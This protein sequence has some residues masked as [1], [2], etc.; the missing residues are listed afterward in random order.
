MYL[1]KL[2]WRKFLKSYK[3]SK[4]QI[5]VSHF[6]EAIQFEGFY[7]SYSQFGE[8]LIL[9]NILQHKEKGF[10]VDIGCNRPIEGNN[11][12]KFYLHGW[13]GINIDG[14]EK[15][16]KQFKK[17]RK[18][19]ISLC[20]IV[21]IN[22]EKIKFFISDDDRVS[23]I[24]EEFK[25]WI[26]E[27]RSYQNYIYVIPKTLE[28]IL[29]QYLPENTKIDFMNIDVEG[30]DL[31]VLNSN[32]FEKHRPGIICIEDHTFSF[33]KKNESKIHQ[34]LIDKNY[35]VI[36]YSSPNLYFKDNSYLM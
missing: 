20:E 34:C 21:S 23:T 19:D 36:A 8:D 31:E 11:T 22:K 6:L 29:D 12:I 3:N 16:I 13:S 33:E 10:F 7:I 17:I 2:L 1:L 35:Q 18:R 5:L 26:K 30:H 25:D 15:L 27:N 24:S 28:E 4:F 32:N 9:K 14:N